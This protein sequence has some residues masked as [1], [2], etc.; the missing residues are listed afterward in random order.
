MY[1][2][3]ILFT[4]SSADGHLGCFHILAVVNNVAVN[5]GV[6]VSFRITVFVFFRYILRSRI[7]GSYGS[8]S[9]L[10]VTGVQ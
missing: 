1:T 10:N 6:H 9:V 5:I 2:C 3:H 7:G 8:Q 4:P